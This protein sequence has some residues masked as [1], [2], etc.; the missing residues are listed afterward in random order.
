[1]NAISRSVT[2]FLSAVDSLAERRAQSAAA[3]A[4]REAASLEIANPLDREIAM[5]FR[6][7]EAKESHLANLAALSELV[8]QANTEP[9]EASERT[10]RAFH[11]AREK[12]SYSAL[13]ALERELTRD[14]E[15][16]EHAVMMLLVQ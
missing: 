10:R 7:H 5:A 4:A 15:D 16:E 14:L 1:M 12:G 6:A 3:H 13:E 11:R 9:V 8:A 2:T